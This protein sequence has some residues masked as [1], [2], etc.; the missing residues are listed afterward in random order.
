LKTLKNKLI[1]LELHLLR[2]EVRASKSEL[3]KFLADDFFEIPSSGIPYDKPHALSRIPDEASPFFTQQDYE[4]T[5]LSENVAQLIYRA[6]VKRENE[7][8]VAYSLRNSIWKMTDGEWQMLFH[9]GTLCEPFD[10][11]GD[12]KS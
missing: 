11:I 10:V 6:T 2:P 1:E 5:V 8:K 9:Q 3:N 7:K 12:E 4:L